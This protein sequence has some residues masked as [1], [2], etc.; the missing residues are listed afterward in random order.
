MRLFFEFSFVAKRSPLKFFDILQ[1]TEV[2]KSPKGPP[3]LVLR[4]CETFKILIFRF[5]VFSKI[6]L[7]SP[8]GPPSS[9]LI[10]CS[11]L[12]F[13]KAQRVPLSSFRHCGTVSKFSFFVFSKVF[14]KKCPNFLLSPSIF[15]IFCNRLDFQKAERVPPFTSLKT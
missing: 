2:S 10:F 5:F 12:K 6:F 7:L 4:H 8:N 13:Q 3:F 15:L 1:Q 11:K 9:F 14:S